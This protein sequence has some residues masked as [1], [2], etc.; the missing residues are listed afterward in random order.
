MVTIEEKLKLF[1]KLLN[2]SMDKELI[3]SLKELENSYEAKINKIKSEV[4][5]EAREIEEKAVKKA[6]IKRTESLSKSK[7][8]I[9]KDIMALKGKY[10]DI[11][12]DKLN[13]KIN[14]FINSKEYETYLSK[15]ISNLVDEIKS[16][17]KCNLVVYLTKNDI[18]KYSDYIKKEITKKHDCNVSFKANSLIKGGIIA[19][20]EDKNLKMDSSI[21]MILEENKTYIMQTIFETLEAGETND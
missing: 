15:I 7:V 18:E 5:K 3:N 17:E 16:Y 2:Q 4:D 1:Y 21:D 10:Y 19:E 11:F 9:K 20:I 8:I 14:I 6:E 13:E 12:M